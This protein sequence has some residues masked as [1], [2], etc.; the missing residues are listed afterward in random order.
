[1]STD[2][3]YHVHLWPRGEGAHRAWVFNLSPQRLRAEV[4]GPWLAGDFF[5]FGDIEWDPRASELRIFEGPRLEAPDLALGEGPNS[6]ERTAEDVTARVL[7]DATI[8]TPSAEGVAPSAPT[9]PAVAGEARVERVAAR[10]LADL[11]A[12]DGD[13]LESEEA[14]DLV[15]ERLRML[16]LD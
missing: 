8:S 9:A 14:L 12:L 4:V 5:E 15:T 7:A 11:A 1:V 3:S 6:A 2:A 10:L 13:S 16:G